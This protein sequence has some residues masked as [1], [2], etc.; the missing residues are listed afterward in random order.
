[1]SEMQ[2][3]VTLTDGSIVKV[4]GLDNLSDAEV[5][6]ALIEALPEKMANLGF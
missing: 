5:T 1:M 4:P 3:T 2:D 6:N